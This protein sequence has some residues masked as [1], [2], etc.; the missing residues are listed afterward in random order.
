MLLW[1]YRMVSTPGRSLQA[2]GPMT[3]LVNCDFCYVEVRD[4]LAWTYLYLP[5]RI[6]AK[7][8][9]SAKDDDGQWAAC[10]DCHGMIKAKDIDALLERSLR[11]DSA[12]QHIPQARQWKHWLF[13]QILNDW[14]LINP[15]YQGRPPLFTVHDA[16]H[17]GGI[18]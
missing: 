8:G 6:P 15:P 14:T 2:G 17:R 11:L 10:E 9:M 12:A 5:V 1:A 13:S 16:Q 7:H 3:K 4:D 18:G